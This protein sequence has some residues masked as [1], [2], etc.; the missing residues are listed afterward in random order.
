MHNTDT[1]AE[2][3]S[4]TQKKREM[5]AL[6]EL[7]EEL[8]QLNAEQLAKIPLSDELRE[9]IS[10]VQ[11]MS[12]RGAR[13]RQTQYIG[14][15]MREVDVAHIQKA[16]DMLRNKNNLA[17]AHF[18]QLEKWRG[19][20]IAGDEG[21]MNEIFNSLPD[22]DIQHLRQ[23]VRNAQKEQADGKTPKASREIFRYLKGLQ[24]ET[25]KSEDRYQITDEREQMTDNDE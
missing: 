21:A 10:A 20:L 14:R 7:G 4:K 5:I 2:K 18:H 23:L 24:E 16:L 15:L 19:Q 22:V 25:Q 17:T 8:A 11:G 13:Y 6:Q 1:A 9:A 3:K 12:K